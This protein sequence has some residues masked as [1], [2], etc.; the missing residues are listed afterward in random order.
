LALRNTLSWGILKDTATEQHLKVNCNCRHELYVRLEPLKNLSNFRGVK[1][2]NR[3]E[4]AKSCKQ[5]KKKRKNSSQSQSRDV[6]IFSGALGNFIVSQNLAVVYN[7]LSAY[8][9]KSSYLL[10]F[11]A[12]PLQAWTHSSGSRRLR[13]S[14]LLVSRHTKVVRFLA[15][16]TGRLYPPGDIPGTHLC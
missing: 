12:I 9:T 8:G 14:E 2:T 7:F 15:L 11:L 4:R 13:L 10:I 6:Q 1:T 16:R 3:I 5:K